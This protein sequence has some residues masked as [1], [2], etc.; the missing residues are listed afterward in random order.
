VVGLDK[1]M[2]WAFIIVDGLSF[3]QISY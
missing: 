2:K 1:E 3:A